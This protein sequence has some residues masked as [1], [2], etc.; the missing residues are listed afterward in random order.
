MVDYWAN[1]TASDLSPSWGNTTAFDAEMQNSEIMIDDV[2]GFTVTQSTTQSSS[3]ISEAGNPN[4]DD[5]EDAG[6]WTIRVST[7]G[8][9]DMRARC[10]ATRLTSVGGIDEQGS[11]TGYQS[12]SG[13]TLIFSPVAPTWSTSE[14]CSHRLAVEFEWD[15]TSTMFDRTVQVQA[16]ADFIANIIVASD[17]SEDSGG[18]TGG[19]TF[20]PKCVMFK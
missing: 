20:V 7:S 2:E 5:W 14:N 12:L 4:N 11:F 1:D 8:V 3:Y 19:V 16:N 13:G 17:I 6:T 15:N 9:M 10:R 18:C